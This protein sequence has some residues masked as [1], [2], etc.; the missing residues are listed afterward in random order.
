MKIKMYNCMMLL[1]LLTLLSTFSCLTLQSKKSNQIDSLSRSSKKGLSALF[2]SSAPGKSAFVNFK[3]KNTNVL[4]SLGLLNKDFVL[5]SKDYKYIQ[6]KQDKSIILK[7]A[8]ILSNSINVKGGAV[9]YNDNNQWRMIVQDSFNK[10][11]TSLGWS[12][13]KTNECTFHKMLGGYCQ[14][15]TKEVQKTI[16]DLPEHSMIR[17]EALY[18]FLGKWDSH[19]GYLKVDPYATDKDMGKYVWTYRC[20][21]LLTTSPTIKFCKNLDVCKIG[22]PINVTMKHSDKK[23]KLIFGSTLDGNPCEQSYGVSDVRIYIR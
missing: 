9:K 17:I 5:M 15:S 10:N 8:S 19:T 3:L 4:Y 2:I 12:S 20:K 22:V 23:I 14:L 16:Q 13:D 7:G 21:N 18:H 1:I 6:V 11:N